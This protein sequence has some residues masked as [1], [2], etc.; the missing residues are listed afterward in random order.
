MSARGLT[1]KGVPPQPAWL[2]Y[3][4]IAILVLAL[5]ILGLAAYSISLFGQYAGLLGG[6]GAGGLLIFVTIKTFIVF[7]GIVAIEIWAP[8][9]F[10]RVIALIAYI[11]SIIF[12]LSGW[13]W[14]ASSAS[15][16]LTSYCYL[17]ACVSPSDYAKAE[18]GALAAAAAL[19]AV[20]WILS[21][22]NLYFFVKACLND[23]DGE[24]APRQ[25]ELGQIK[26]EPTP[27]QTYPAGQQQ[28]GQQ[29][30]QA[31]GYPQ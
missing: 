17:G 10:Y 5:I 22:V 19:G 27:T 11:L 4:K 24:A 13:A 25:A 1:A 21:I 28:Y 16:W 23:P 8:Q 9:Y 7:G 12:W 15:F 26:Q 3:I 18:G 30:Y 6:S 20:A 31:G 29:Q 14:A 2:L